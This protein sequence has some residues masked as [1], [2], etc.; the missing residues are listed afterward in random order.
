MLIT[1]WAVVLCASAAPAAP[2]WPEAPSAWVCPPAAPVDPGAWCRAWSPPAQGFDLLAW[3]AGRA[4]LEPDAACAPTSEVPPPIDELAGRA[5]YERCLADFLGALKHH[6]PALAWAVD[7]AWRLTGP[8]AGT[9][10][11][12][13]VQCARSNGPHGVVRTWYSPP[14]VAWLCAGRPDDGPPEGALIVQERLPITP[15]AVVVTADANDCVDVQPTEAVAAAMAAIEAQRNTIA[16]P[17]ESPP[18]PPPPAWT[19]AAMVRAPAASHDGWYWFEGEQRLTG[20]SGFDAGRMGVAAHVLNPEDGRIRPTRCGSATE[21][22]TDDDCTTGLVD[23]VRPR[24]GFGPECLACHAAARSASTF[25][26][27]A[28][29][30]GG[31]PRFRWFAE[32]A[33]KGKR[34]REAPAATGASGDAFPDPWPVDAPAVAAFA[35]F[36]DQLAVPDGERLFALRLP[37][38]TWDHAVARPEQPG[39]FVTSDQCQACH[40]A[41]LDTA[42]GEAMRVEVR[43]GKGA[44]HLLDLSAYGE[45]RASP[46]AQSARNPIFLAHLQGE[47]NRH[48]RHAACLENACLRCHAPMGERAQAA[49]TLRSPAS[50][51][52]NTL[53][54]G[55][56]PPPEVPEGELF[57]RANLAP[58]PG[59]DGASAAGQRWAALG[60]DGVSCAVCHRVAEDGL[61]SVGSGTGLWR[62]GPA[63]VLY[64]PSADARGEAMKAA[65]GAAPVEGPHLRSSALCGTCHDLLL[66]VFDEKGAL[67]RHEYEQTTHLEWLN[68]AF[69][70]HAAPGEARTC[71]SCHLPHTAPST[72][73][74][75]GRLPVLA[76]PS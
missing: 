68:S 24:N 13:Q 5:C 23:A 53:M 9:Q 50:A 70:A 45:W 42:A 74:A 35:A 10:A 32:A 75:R 46:L 36:H 76:G 37:A 57:R 14:M 72:L 73:D 21:E 39:G 59:R 63:G 55:L 49:D 28:Q 51:E 22:P 40:A 60:R 66:P 69:G 12:E 41:R 15:D 30:A 65:V 4:D 48:P 38:E 43:D 26:D 1:A 33:R 52:C 2:V 16:A 18:K 6:D 31:G 19:L 20:R 8:C 67:C 29:L 3:C 58:W 64:G 27:L 71:Q 25:A 56:P 62:T 17:G 47:T 44:R 54:F 7:P 11:G 61:D 34:T